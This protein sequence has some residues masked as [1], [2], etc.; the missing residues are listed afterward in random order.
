MA[1]P[2]TVVKSFATE[3]EILEFIS[4]VA[5]SV[6]KYAS[7]AGIKMGGVVIAQC[8]EESGYGFSSRAVYQHNIVGDI[9]TGRD[10]GTWDNCIKNYFSWDI[11]NTPEAKAATT[12]DQYCDALFVHNSTGYIYGEDVRDSLIRPIYEKF[13]L[14]QYDGASGSNKLEEFVQKALSYVGTG[15]GAWAAAHP[16]WYDAGVWCADF[17]SAVGEEVDILGKVFDGSPSA[18][19]CA[20]SVEKYGGTV[21]D[22]RTYNPQRGDLINFMWGGGAVSGGYADHIGIVTS[23]DNGVVHTVE[24]NTSDMVA[25]RSYDRSSSVLACFCSPDWS[26][27]GGYATGGGRYGIQGELFEEKNTRKDATVREVAYL[28]TVYMERQKDIIEKYEPVVKED[29]IKLSIVN[30]TELFQAFWEVG[31]SLFKAPDVSGE[32]DY[33]QLEPKVREIVQY[34]VGKGLNNAAACGICGNIY[35]ESSFRTEAVGDGGTSFGICQWHA[36]RGDSMKQM[37][38]SNWSSNLTGQLDYLWYELEFNYSGVLTALKNVPNTEEG[39]KTAADVFVRRFEIPADV[40]NQSIKRQQKAAEYFNQIVQIVTSSSS[41]SWSQTVNLAN[42]S[43]PRKKIL[44][45]AYEQ[46]EAGTPYV[47]GG[48]EPGRGLDC[49][50][51]TQ[52]CYK[53]AGIYISHYTESQFAEA[54]HRL[55]VSEA[56][57]GDILYHPGHVAIFIGDGKTIEEYA[58]GPETSFWSPG[59]PIGSLDVGGRFSH[60]L[61]WDI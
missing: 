15:S 32:W 50:G 20:H 43:E 28:K 56:S 42:C 37:A 21:H 48:E 49:S 6:T 31:K 22:E 5:P 34:L 10:Y 27:V 19:V 54:P 16:R 26:K 41:S 9:M 52:Y 3:E 45:A 25:E 11:I 51:L 46:L 12:L 57:L 59:G 58:G 7:E 4:M 61:H 1:T 39:A 38:G 53:Q 2:G 36:G 17:V 44:A 14:S 33:S 40:D 18:Y 60:A 55:S 8:C 29:S 24:G 23:Y 30:Y 13:N 35:F 47:W